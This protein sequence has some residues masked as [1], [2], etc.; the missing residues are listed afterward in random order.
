MVDQALE[1]QEINL[2]QYPKFTKAFDKAYPYKTTELTGRRTPLERLGVDFLD[3]FGLGD[4]SGKIVRDKKTEHLDFFNYADFDKHIFATIE[5]IGV[6]QSNP[7]IKMDVS[8]DGDR[9]RQ[10]DPK[11]SISLIWGADSGSQNKKLRGVGIA[12]KRKDKIFPSDEIE[13][14]LDPESGQ[15]N[16]VKIPAEDLRD[17]WEEA[18]GIMLQPN[19]NVAEL[20]PTGSDYN[21]ATEFLTQLTGVP[22]DVFSSGIDVKATV[23]E[24]LAGNIEKHN[25]VVS[26]KMVKL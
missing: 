14:R 23:K 7:R 6:M 10:D 2:D 19:V 22:K 16:G 11:V 4:F 15:L 13:V 21:K 1:K 17:E 26:P 9:E 5:T 12:W 3:S 20:D 25:N 18:T 8:F 24:L